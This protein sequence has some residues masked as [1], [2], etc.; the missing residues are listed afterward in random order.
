ME[1]QAQRCVWGKTRIRDQQAGVGG[2]TKKNPENA[3]AVL[4]GAG[5]AEVMGNRQN[6]TELLPVVKL[7]EPRCSQR[8]S[9]A[10]STPQL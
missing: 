1:R 10:H 3:L 6:W 2:G 9:S 4:Q 5:Q 8:A 7:N